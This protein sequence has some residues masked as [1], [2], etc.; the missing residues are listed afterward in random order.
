MMQKK[1][2]K[3]VRQCTFWEGQI[4]WSERET[5]ELWVWEMEQF[6]ERVQQVPSLNQSPSTSL[7]RELTV[8]MLI[9]RLSVFHKTTSPLII[10]P[11]C[12][13]LGTKRAELSISL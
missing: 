9:P 4:L 1:K 11:D 12:W 3:T 8:I 2:Y 7:L 6:Q 10:E 5:G 13:K